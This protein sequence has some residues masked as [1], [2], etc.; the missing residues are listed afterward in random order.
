[1]LNQMATFPNSDTIYCILKQAFADECSIPRICLQ[2]ALI[3]THMSPA[4]ITDETGCKTLRKT[5]RVHSH[6]LPTA[7][8]QPDQRMGKISTRKAKRRT[9]VLNV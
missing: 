6:G 9:S 7:V 5:A 1:M 8:Q 4:D 3:P 2:S